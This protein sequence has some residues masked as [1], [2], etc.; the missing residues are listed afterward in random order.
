M[1]EYYREIKFVEDN[2]E[3]F[4]KM[5]RFLLEIKENEIDKSNSLTKVTKNE[6]NISNNLAKVS[7]NETDISSNLIKI[8]HIENNTSKVISEGIFQETYDIENQEFNFNNDTHFYKLVK[9][10]VSSNFTKVGELKIRNNVYYKY[11]NSKNVIN[12]LCYDYQFY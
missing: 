10:E 5:A 4:L 9:T 3:N 2:I 12:R 6:N 1:D 11:N 7:K 8:T